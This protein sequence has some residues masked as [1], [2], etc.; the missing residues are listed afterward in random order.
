MLAAG[1]GVV[2]LLSLLRR[3]SE[4]RNLVSLSDDALAGRRRLLLSSKDLI[5]TI[6]SRTQNLS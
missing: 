5:Y 6:A 1:L 4:L 3:E 2:R